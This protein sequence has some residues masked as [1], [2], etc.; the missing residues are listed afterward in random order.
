MLLLENHK[1]VQ[2][3]SEEIAGK[4]TL[5]GSMFYDGV[6]ILPDSAFATLRTLD[7]DIGDRF[8]LSQEQLQ[9]KIAKADL[10]TFMYGADGSIMSRAHELNIDPMALGTWPITISMAIPGSMRVG[11]RLWHYRA[12]AAS[13]PNVKKVN[14][15]TEAECAL[16]A[17]LT[18]AQRRGGIRGVVL[19]FFGRRTWDAD[20]LTD[21]CD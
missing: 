4:G 13:S 20:I 16:K 3:E 6:E 11:R 9:M 15:R 2:I 14:I 19:F 5:M 8:N 7:N 1:L 18:N 12:A 10:D 21:P 17:I